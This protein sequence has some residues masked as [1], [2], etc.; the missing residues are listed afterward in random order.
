[1]RRGSAVS[2][3]LPARRGQQLE[4]VLEVADSLLEDP[5]D[6]VRKGYGWMLKEASK[7]Y[8]QQVF[9][10]VLQRRGL[11]PRVALRY[12]IEKLPEPLRRQAMEKK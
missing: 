11:M 1:M 9:D 7:T 8:P 5:Q 12:A 10:Y 3:V 6:L 2:L 4:L